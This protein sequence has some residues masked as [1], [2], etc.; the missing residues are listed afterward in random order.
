MNNTTK[1]GD[2]FYKAT[3]FSFL[4]MLLYIPTNTSQNLISDVQDKSGF[5]NLGFILLG[6]FYLFQ[7]IGALCSA[8]FIQNTGI[9]KGM[10]I[11]SFFL[12]FFIMG[13]ILSA[14]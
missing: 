10:V 11:G 4:F 13:C 1:Y 7:M 3:Y 14:W 12:S 9:T 8:A 2:H 6:I 5:G